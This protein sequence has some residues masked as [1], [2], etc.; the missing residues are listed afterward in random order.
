MST[1]TVI[2]T[3]NMGTQIATL[4][5]KGGAQVQV[6]DR[7]A[8][9]AAALAGSVG[10]TP[11]VVGD[12]LTGDI[13]VLAVPYPALDELL[14]TYADQLAGRTLVDITNPVVV[15]ADSSA[16]AQL[17]ARVPGA[18]VLKAFNTTF[19]G[20][21]AAG[22]VGGQPATVLVAGDDAAA[23]TAFTDVFGPAVGVVD[24][25]SLRR[26]R[27]LEALGFLQITLAVGGSTS[28]GTGFTLVR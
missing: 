24:V 19:A 9:K 17:A 7:V 23:K 16:A 14:G 21:L 6:L 12:A 8:D 20:A 15:P 13:V 26:A 18:A 10:G 27:E 11:G 2:G 25:G 22:E 1:V 28:W 3:G 4:A 5:A